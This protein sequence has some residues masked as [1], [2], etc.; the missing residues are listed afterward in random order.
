RTRAALVI[1]DPTAP[2]GTGLDPLPGA[3]EEARRVVARLRGTRLRVL[4]G[5]SASEAAIKREAGDYS[6]LHFA[7]HGLIAPERPLSSSLL[8]AAGDGDDG[9]LR[10]DEVVNLDLHADLIVLSGCSTALGKLSG[11]GIIGLTRAFIYAG[12][13]S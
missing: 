9:Y 10:V 7:T 3:R 8:L 11:D 12:T 13:P 2:P 1:A 4:T 5:G 6:L